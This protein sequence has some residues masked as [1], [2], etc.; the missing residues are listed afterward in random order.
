VKEERKK[1]GS[2]ER[3]KMRKEYIKEIKERA[4]MYQRD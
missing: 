4:W 1:N 2:L 3:G